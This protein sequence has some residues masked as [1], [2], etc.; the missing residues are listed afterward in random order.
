MNLTIWKNININI[1]NSNINNDEEKV[2][3]LPYKYAQN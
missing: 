3:I 2:T 1:N